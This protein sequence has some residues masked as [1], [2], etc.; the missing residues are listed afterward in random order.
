MAFSEIP[1][2]S[3]WR[4]TKRETSGNKGENSTVKSLWSCIQT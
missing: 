1:R 4:Q 3:S 2:C